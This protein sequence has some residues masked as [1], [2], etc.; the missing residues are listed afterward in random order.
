MDTMAFCVAPSIQQFLNDSTG[1][2]CAQ[3]RKQNFSFTVASV[4]SKYGNSPALILRMLLEIVKMII[5]HTVS[6]ISSS[7]DFF[8]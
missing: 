8:P 4:K 3:K 2:L 7:Q 5:T 1:H 6:N